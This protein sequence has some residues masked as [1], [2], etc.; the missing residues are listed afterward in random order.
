MLDFLILSKTS[1][2]EWYTLLSAPGVVG[3]NLRR[4]YLGFEAL[5]AELRKTFSLEDFTTANKALYAEVQHRASYS[6]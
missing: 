3:E 2:G 5:S 1:C 4:V 6:R